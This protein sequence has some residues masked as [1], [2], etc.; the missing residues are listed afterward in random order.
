MGKSRRFAAGKI[1]GGFFKREG[2]P[3]EKEILTSRLIDRPIRPLFPEQFRNEVQVVCTLLSHDLE[4]DPDIVAM[5]GTSAALAISGVP[6]NGPIGG[7]RVASINNQLVLNPTLGQM[8]ESKL[9]LVV[10]GTEDAILMVE[11]EVQELS[12]AETLDAIMFGHQGYLPVIKMIKEFAAQ[13]A[14][15]ALAFESMDIPGTDYYKQLMALYNQDVIDAYKEP[16]KQKRYQ[17]LKT[18]KEKATA[19]ILAADASDTDKILFADAFK[20]VE[21]DVLRGNILD[22]NVRTDGRAPEQIRKITPEVSVLQR[23]HG[24]ALFTRG[25]TQALVVATLGTS[26]DEQIIDSIEGEYRESFMLHYNF[27]QFS[28]GEVGKIGS[29]GRREI[30]HG[31]LARRAL[32]PMLPRKWNYTIRLVSEILSSNGSTSMAT[33]CGGSLALMDA[34][35]PM[36]RPV[37]GIAMGLIKSADR[38]VI[39]SDISGDE[40]RLGDMDFKVAGTSVGITA[41]QMDMKIGGINREIMVAALQQ[42]KTGRMH[43]LNEMTR[44]L[45]TPRDT[46]S[47]YAPRM[48]N[49]KI[50]PD[51]IREV[52]GSGGKVIKEICEVTGAK[53][54][55]EQDGTVAVAGLSSENVQ[56]AIDWILDIAGDP[57]MGKVY[58]G[59]VVKIAEF[60][61]FVSF[62]NSREGLVHVSEM[63]GNK[64]DRSR[65]VTDIL[66]VGDN[67]Q[68][69]FIGFGDKGKLRLR[70]VV[71]AGDAQPTDEIVVITDDVKTPPRR[72]RN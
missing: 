10:A 39:L 3:S 55:I 11:A 34:G 59:K 72:S 65:K 71:E 37:A 52:I 44:A 22:S 15:P 67:V 58:P 29:P 40:D 63:G 56:R 14:R 46:T 38:F 64:K 68:V 28:V 20:L 62:M 7:S 1:P 57:E 4:N 13:A 48:V 12:E 49:I 32:R 36:Q 25:E 47:Q 24:S 45:E 5:I 61:A 70:L 43:I 31:N 41:L 33:V 26:Q 53:I 6:F 16:Q 42:A 30:G 50:N 18:L 27:P 54:D 2:R 21:Y 23:V 8:A 69:E 66:S 9:D 60:G 19:K 35:V 51:K 17:M